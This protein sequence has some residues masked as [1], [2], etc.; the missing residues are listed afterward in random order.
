MF[1]ISLLPLFCPL[2][3]QIVVCE[4]IVFAFPSALFSCLA[5]LFLHVGSGLSHTGTLGLSHTGMVGLSHTDFWGVR[6]AIFFFVFM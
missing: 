5:P 2:W 4:D 6:A 3:V 1:H